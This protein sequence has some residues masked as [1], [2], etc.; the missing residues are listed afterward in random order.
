MPLKRK[1]ALHN[2][3]GLCKSLFTRLFDHIVQQVNSSLPL[4]E[5]SSSYIGVLD[6]AGFGAY[7]VLVTYQLSRGVSRDVIRHVVVT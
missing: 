3:D 5:K 1:E 4:S 2:R 6:I 7:H